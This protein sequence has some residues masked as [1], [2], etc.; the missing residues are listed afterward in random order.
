MNAN[1]YEVSHIDYTSFIEQI[2]PEYRKI[3]IEEIG[4]N[5]IASKVYSAKTGKCLCSRVTYSGDYE[6]E[7]YQPEK[8]YIFGMPDNDERRPPIPKLR[9]NLENTKEI[10]AFLNFLAKQQEENK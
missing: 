1:I 6:D 7:R 4:N 10:Q 3:K 2:K 9:L 8:Y 5:H